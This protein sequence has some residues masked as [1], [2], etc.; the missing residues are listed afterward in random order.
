MNHCRTFL[1]N[2]AEGGA[3][4]TGPKCTRCIFRF[5]LRGGGV[6][7]FSHGK[8][9]CSR[10]HRKFWGFL[11]FQT[12]LLENRIVNVPGGMFALL[13]PRDVTDCSK[14]SGLVSNRAG[15]D[16]S[17]WMLYPTETAQLLTR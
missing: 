7:K 13:Y 11:L 6:S 17:Y 9:F 3:A 4:S 8:G 12:C 16:Y 2:P 14:C 1:Q 15:Q 5:N 10:V